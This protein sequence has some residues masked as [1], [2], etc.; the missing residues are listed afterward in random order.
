MIK[1]QARV[2]ITS[3]QEEGHAPSVAPDHGN[4]DRSKEPVMGR[5]SCQEQNGGGHVLVGFGS[6]IASTN[7][8]ATEFGGCNDNGG[9]GC[10]SAYGAW[11]DKSCAVSGGGCQTCIASTEDVCFP[12]SEQCH[13]E[14]CV[15]E[16]Y[17]AVV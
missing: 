12:D 14:T 11:A 7:L 13:A 3:G 10:A 17:K 15:L 8:A 2:S 16:G 6:A 9:W 1:E 4:A 5:N